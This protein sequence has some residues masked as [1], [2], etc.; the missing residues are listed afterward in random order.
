ML[1]VAM[2]VGRG[3]MDDMVRGA[4]T[5]PFFSELLR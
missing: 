5:F 1:V 4:H 2:A 3:D